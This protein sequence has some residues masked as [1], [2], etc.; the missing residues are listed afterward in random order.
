[1]QNINEKSDEAKRAEN[2]AFVTKRKLELTHGKRWKQFTKDAL[3]AKE[4]MKARGDIRVTKAQKPLRKGE[5]RTLD[6]RTG[7]WKSNLK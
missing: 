7:K 6:K 5:V 3:A 4:R 1:M 2:Q